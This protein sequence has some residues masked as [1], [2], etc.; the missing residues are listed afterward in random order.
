MATFK[1]YTTAAEIDAACV[2]FF[3]RGNA[4]QAGAHKL[5]C[6][7]LR[8]VGE[9]GDVRV[10]SKFIASFPDMARVNAVKAW[11]EAHGPVTFENAG[12]VNYVKGGKTRLGEAMEIPFWKFAPEAEYKPIDP[13]KALNSLIAKLE[14]DAKLT[15]AD[16][17]GL[18]LSLKTIR[19]NSA[20][21]QNAPA[22]YEIII[23]GELK[24]LPA[25]R[26]AIN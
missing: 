10:V 18:I 26:P 22:E 11:F 25:P 21:T 13:A 5:A 15:G 1:L 17:S 24:M 7:V 8:H 3:K 19:A 12:V 20:T 23:P 6:S 4:L 16:H 14:K 2:S 9:H